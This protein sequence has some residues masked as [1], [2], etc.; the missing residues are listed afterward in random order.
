MSVHT[1]RQS[2]SQDD[3]RRMLRGDSPEDR[4]EAVHRLCRRIDATELSDEDRAYAGQILE[5]LAG[6]TVEQVR[7]ALAI[8]L[9]SSPNL[10]REVA[11]KLIRDA[12]S[13]AV[14]LLTHSPVLT[15]SDLLEVVLSYG[16]THQVAIA[17]R[18]RLSPSVCEAIA[19]HGTQPAVRTMAGNEGAV[20]SGKAYAHTLRRFHADPEVQDALVH[21][22]R[23]PVQVAEKLVSLVTGELFDHLVNN[24]ELPPQLAIDLATGARERATLDLLEQAGRQR[25]MPR[26]VQQLN[27]AGKLTSSMVL[28]GLC[29][30]HMS[31][32][33]WALAELS[34]VAHHKV[35]LMVHD[36]GNMGLRAIL[37]HAG[38]PPRLY[39]V[40]RIAIDVF[41]ETPLDGGSGDLERFRRRMVER[42]L[43]QMQQIPPDDLAYLLDKLNV[44]AAAQ[45]PARQ[46]R[47]GP[48]ASDS[49]AGTA[50]TVPGQRPM[51]PLRP[52]FA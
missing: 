10:P 28:R 7:R 14:P 8:T 20:M 51:T 3:I 33:E 39:P 47:P 6:D 22:P 52:R 41:H 25:D 36:A 23:L 43:T 13:I 19:E 18:P 29:L 30:G 32:V 5:I 42:V 38:L 27:L 9:Q 31:F 34:G 24:H 37:E 40:F 46:A 44:P 16:V 21:R 17:N 45:P 26:F 11:A 12:E 48:V 2:L 50:P 1:L 15:D 49:P 35:W 4:A